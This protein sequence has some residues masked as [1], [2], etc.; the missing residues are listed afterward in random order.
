MSIRWR[1]SIL[2]ILA[3]LT[4]AALLDARVA[5]AGHVGANLLFACLA[6]NDLYKVVTADGATYPRFDQPAQAVAAAGVGDG[7]LIL[8]DGYPATP[9]P[10]DAALFRHATEKKLRLYVEY[11]SW[12]PDTTVG[13]VQTLKFGAWGAILERGVVTSEFFGADLPPRS[14]VMINDCHYVSVAAEKPHLALAEVAGY[15]R[16]VLGLPP[17]TEPILFEL[18]GRGALVSTTKLSQFVTARYAPTDAWRSIWQGIVEWL[19]PGSDVPKL[20]WTPP[21]RPTYTPAEPLPPGAQKEAVRRGGQWFLRSGLLVDPA[22][23]YREHRQDELKPVLWPDWHPGDG[24]KGILEAYMSRTCYDGRQGVSLSIRSD[25]NAEAA[26]AMVLAAEVLGSEPLRATAHRLTKYTF[27]DMPTTRSL[28]ADPDNARYGLIGWSLVRPRS[29]YGDDNART[30]LGTMAVA[31]AEKCDTFDP[32]LVRGILANFR[33][34]G[35]KGSRPGLIEDGPLQERGWRY[36]WE[37]DTVEN[38]PHY[39]AWIWATYLWLY[40]QTHFEPLK[41]RAREGIRRMMAAYPDGW[42]AECGRREADLARMLLPL[43]WLVR[44]DDSPEPRAWLR[45]IAADLIAVQEPCGAIPQRPAE[46]LAA[47]EQYGKDES[48]I[49]Y[50]TGDPAADLLYTVNFAAIGLHEAAAATGDAALAQAADRIAEFLVRCQVRSDAHPE[51]DGAWFRSFDFRRW[52]LWGSDGDVGWGIWAA[53]TGWTQGWIVTTLALRE[54]HTSLW[55]FTARSRVSEQF[56]RE[57]RQMLTDEV[58]TSVG[59]ASPPAEH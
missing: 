24:S 46:P 49:V 9:T 40:H 43:A 12:L 27:F 23:K 58:L 25:C 41:E 44:V 47:N 19:R 5:V 14:L 1:V 4:S 31:A 56:E 59:P 11:P 10:L 7:L 37:H 26:M 32:C 29:Y 18:P 8:A 3:A 34:T 50:A 38:S 57:R 6:D 16:A 30:L 54:L 36:Y 21:V 52:E 20:R 48:S 42:V 33:T 13:R 51:L 53:E 55:D 39:A 15:N 22:W 28:H 17:H 35:P 45:R 2:L